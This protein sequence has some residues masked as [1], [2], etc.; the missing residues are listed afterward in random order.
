M[1]IVQFMASGS[2]GG[3][4]KVFVELAN[5]LS[6]RHSVIA[7]VIRNCQFIHRFSAKVQVV[8]LESHPTI[9]N[10]FLHY[11]LFRVLHR[12]KPDIIHT[13]AAKATQLVKRVNM[14]CDVKHL[15]TKHNDRN[16]RIFNRLRWVTAV[17]E[18]ARQSIRPVRDCN[19]SVIHNGV[20]E[21]PITL[22]NK[23]DIFTLLGVGRLD[24]IKGFDYLIQQVADLQFPFRLLLVG[25]GPEHGAL[26]KQ[27]SRLGLEEK[28]QLLGFREDIA[29]MMHDAHLVVISS[30]REGG[31]KVMLEA[32]LYAD[33]LVSTPVGAVPD[34]L[35]EYFQAQL[36]HLGKKIDYIYNN[37]VR[38]SQQ[39]SEVRDK[40][41]ADFA[42]SKIVEEYEKTYR[43]IVDQ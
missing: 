10:P 12:L 14:F 4:E 11:E 5:A 23:S 43:Q 6:E 38:Y 20:I 21:E 9:N 25:E 29:Q 33:A 7:L 1:K 19:I 31:P 35:P 22:R 40:K 42:F 15:G 24:K 36:H 8:E 27:I 2:F 3:A 37:Y 39:F 30:H 28:V 34:V 32:L 26:Q 18:K 16:G 13:H 17:S 41:K